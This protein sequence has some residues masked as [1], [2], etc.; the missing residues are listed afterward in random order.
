MLLIA[1]PGSNRVRRHRI[2]TALHALPQAGISRLLSYTMSYDIKIE[3]IILNIRVQCYYN[4]GQC[5]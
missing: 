5:I 3:D 1:L 4:D 2:R